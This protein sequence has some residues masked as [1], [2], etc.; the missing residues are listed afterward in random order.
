MKITFAALVA[1]CYAV[2]GM[3][4]CNPPYNTEGAACSSSDG[5]S[6]ESCNS[7]DYASVVSSVIAQQL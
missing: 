7:N 6:G 4:Q 2:G 1:V 3:A 5:L